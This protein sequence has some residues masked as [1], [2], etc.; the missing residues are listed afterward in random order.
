MEKK[1][2]P[3]EPQA[4]LLTNQDVDRDVASLSEA[5]VE[6]HARNVARHVLLRSD[7]RQILQAL[8]ASGICESEEEAIVRGLRTLS[9]AVLKAG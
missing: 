9:V 8:V 7:V 6:E 3:H 4:A 1:I 2:A 5:L